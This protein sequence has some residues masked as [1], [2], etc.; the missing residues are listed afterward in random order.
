MI[1]MAR[2]VR[3][4]PGMALATAIAALALIADAAGLT[5]FRTWWIPPLII[6]LVIGMML[7]PVGK[8]ALFAPGIDVAGRTILR[9]GVALLGVRLTFGDMVAGGIAPVLVAFCAVFATIGFGGLVS[10]WFGL[11]RDFGFLTGCS[12]GVCGA[13]AAMAAGAVLPKHENAERDV[14]FTVMGVNTLST[15]AMIV[16]PS[17]QHSLGFSNFEMGVF[18]GGA[19]H[20]VAQVAGAGRM[21][22][23]QV[24][25]DSVMTKLIRV[26]F[27]LPAVMAIAWW[28]RST[29]RKAGEARLQPPWFLFGFIALAAINSTGVIP[30]EVQN[31]V[32]QASTIFITVAIA[33]LGVK[34]S[35]PGMLAIGVRPLALLVLETLFI[36]VLVVSILTLL[37]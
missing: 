9:L 11:S 24:L 6:A 10:V 19:I 35:L 31:I 2:L 17:L 21:M 7:R 30:R 25:A 16:Y 13:A 36:L 29:G 4:L 5:H 32:Q 23:D 8:Q 12:V 18:L 33:A 20:D 37:H 34:T 3:L 1:D 15:I 28:V 14:V 27:L 22:S 26:A